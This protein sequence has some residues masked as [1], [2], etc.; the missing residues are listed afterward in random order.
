MPKAKKEE[1]VEELHKAN[2]EFAVE[3]EKLRL[4]VQ[5]LMKAS[6]NPVLKSGATDT[7]E[8]QVGQDGVASFEDDELVH[9]EQRTL[10]D[11]AMLAKLQ[12]EQFMNEPVKVHILDVAEEHADV[13]FTVWVNGDPMTFIRNN[14]YT[15]KRKF[16]EGL[17]RAKK[18][19]YG[20]ALRVDQQTGLQSYVWPSK[21]GLRYPF[22]VVEDKNPRGKTWLEAVLRQP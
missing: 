5:R 11:P 18:T 22:A 6:S 13:G 19:S 7:Q 10:D 1:V 3:N 2:E 8:M 15:V 14:E 4:E 21:T 17:A 16:V 20:N 9:V 12:T